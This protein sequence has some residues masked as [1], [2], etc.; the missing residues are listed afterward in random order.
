MR[1]KT[2]T[3]VLLALVALFA[4]Y[5]G[6]ST[7]SLAAGKQAGVVN[8]QQSQDQTPTTLQQQ[9]Q[10]QAQLA[11]QPQADPSVSGSGG[12]R[13]EGGAENENCEQPGAE[14]GEVEDQDEPGDVD[15]PCPERP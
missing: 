10:Q 7:D 8:Q 14:P 3:V 2:Q 15:K 5:L 1:L 12:E 6:R 4:F 13:S 9:A 11:K